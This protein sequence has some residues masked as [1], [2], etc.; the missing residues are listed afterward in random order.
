MHFLHCYC[1]TLDRSVPKSRNRLRVLTYFIFF[2]HASYCTVYCTIT[3]TGTVRTG[4]C[5]THQELKRITLI[6]A[7]LRNANRKDSEEG[8][9]EAE[10]TSLE[11][12]IPHEG[13][14]TIVWVFCLQQKLF[15]LR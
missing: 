11:D 7:F 6:E 8:D 10:I 14:T 3:V 5:D 9:K 15:L 1:H 4:N 2:E 13:C 12:T